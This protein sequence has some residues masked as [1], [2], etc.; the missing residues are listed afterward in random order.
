MPVKGP[1]GGFKGVIVE[2]GPISEESQAAK[3]SDRHARGP[4]RRW[5]PVP[6]LSQ[7][8]RDGCRVF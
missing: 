1:K 6:A 3:G 2:F 4:R 8:K 5:L 7:A